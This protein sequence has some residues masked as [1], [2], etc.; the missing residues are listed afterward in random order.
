[1]EL[2]DFVN[3]A[4]VRVIQSGC[5]ARFALESLERIGMPGQLLGEKLKR[6]KP[7]EPGVL[8]L[9]D[10]AHTAATQPLQNPVTGDCR[11]SYLLNRCNKTIA[12]AGQ[13]LDVARI[14]GGVAQGR[15]E[16]GHRTVDSVVK[17]HGGVVGPEPRLD[18]FAA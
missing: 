2:I 12:T 16:P 1:M 17:I 6:Q 14:A 13:G 10:H 18:L 15:T 7:P 9:V 3:R 8:G 5:G 4:D 11:R